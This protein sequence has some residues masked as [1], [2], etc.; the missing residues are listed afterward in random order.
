LWAETKSFDL[1]IDLNKA[2][3]L[4]H[5]YWN[6]KQPGNDSFDNSLISQD[7]FELLAN[8]TKTKMKGIPYFEQTLIHLERLIETL[9]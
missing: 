7:A 1:L 8:Y 2:N 6:I 9:G 4:G 5:L 3:Q